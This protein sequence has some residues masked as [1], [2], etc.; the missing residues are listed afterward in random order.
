MAENYHFQTETEAYLFNE[1]RKTRK[2]LD[3]KTEEVEELKELLSDYEDDT[4]DF[5]SEVPYNHF[6]H[7]DYTTFEFVLGVEK[8]RIEITKVEKEI[9]IVVHSSTNIAEADFEK[10]LFPLLSSTEDEEIATIMISDRFEDV[11][12]VNYAN[13]VLI[14]SF[15]LKE[16]V[17]PHKINISV[18]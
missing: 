9:K 6:S 10:K 8:D 16:E 5:A 15:K 12:T 4:G 13:G 14:L 17:K 18:K 11:P 1:L 2:E 7:G 3:M